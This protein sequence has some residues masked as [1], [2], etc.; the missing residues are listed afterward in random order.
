MSSSF[1]LFLSVDLS[2]SFSDVTVLIN[3]LFYFSEQH[4][5]VCSSLCMS[6]TLMPSSC[7]AAADGGAF[8]FVF[9]WIQ[10]RGGEF[11]M[12]KMLM[13]KR[14]HR[15]SSLWLGCSAQIGSA[16]THTDTHTYTHTQ[17]PSDPSAD[18]SSASARQQQQLPD[19]L[20]FSQFCTQGFCCS[21]VGVEVKGRWGVEARRWERKRE[22]G[23]RTD[24][25]RMTE[26]G[27]AS[28]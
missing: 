16:Q 20:S 19:L 22:K 8:A 12:G 13:R 6:V 28:L 5:W 17:R 11:L 15:S 27:I 1:S 3:C 26:N 10:G 7:G 2:L 14:A 23:M 21:D 18:D 24:D 4:K 9:Q 25:G